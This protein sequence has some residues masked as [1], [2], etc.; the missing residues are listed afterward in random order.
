MKATVIK[1]NW[2]NTWKKRISL[3][4]NNINSASLNVY[5]NILLNSNYNS[6][7]ED[8]D[9]KG[10]DDVEKENLNLEEL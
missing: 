10:I 7:Q 4:I 8:K 6:V 2:L 5:K 3:R 9:P 1:F